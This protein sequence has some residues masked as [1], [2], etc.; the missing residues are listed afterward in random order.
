MVDEEEMKTDAPETPAAA[1]AKG[2]GMWI[3]I[4]VVVIVIVILLAAVF[5][6]LFGAPAPDLPQ[7]VYHV[8]YPGDAGKYLPTLW[9]NRAQWTATWFFSEGLKDQ[10]FINQLNTSGIDVSRIVGTAPTTSTDPA[11]LASG[12]AFNQNYTARFV[13]DTEPG[14]FAPH[15]YDGLFLIALAMAD[16]N[17][18]DVTSAAFKAAMRNGHSARGMG[19]GPR[20]NRRESRHRL[21]RRVRCGELRQLRRGP[22]RLR[23]VGRQRGLQA[24]RAE[25][26]HPRG[27]LVWCAVSRAIPRHEG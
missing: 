14:L 22:I 8:G 19:E 20:R 5:G 26:V 16:A 17:T 15:A 6:G 2:K 11:I 3:G 9:A 13:G 18:T 4:V 27:Q 24:D 12:T 1:P 21:R 25:T 23:G 10:A 7:A